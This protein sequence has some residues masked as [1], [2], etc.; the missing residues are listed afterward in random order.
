M[1]RQEYVSR[2][3]RLARNA[4]VLPLLYTAISAF[5]F[6]LAF[7]PWHLWPLAWMALVPFLLAL[8]RVPLGRALLLAWVWTMVLSLTV[9]RWFGSGVASYFGQSRAFGVAVFIAVPT[10]TGALEYMAFAG[11]YRAGRGMGGSVR[12]LLAG[13][14]W[15]AAELC[16]TRLFTGNPWGLLAYSQLDSGPLVHIADTTGVYGV[17]F[18][19]ATFNA[20][21]AGL[22]AARASPRVAWWSA[23]RGVLLSA[24]LG[25]LAL[26]YGWLRVSMTRTEEA[27]VMSRPVAVIQGNVD[28]GTQWRSDF[29]GKNLDVYLGLTAGALRAVSPAV[30]FWP[31]NAMT[32]FLEAEPSY[33]AT[34]ATVLAPGAV[35]LVAGGPRA[36][37]DRHEPYYNSALL[38][39]PDGT[40]AAHYDKERLIPFAERLPLLRS[41]V[42]RRRFGR[43]REFTPGE[44]TPPLQTAAGP[45]GV[46]ICNEG[47]LPELAAARVRAGAG[48]LVI[49]ANDAWAN[50]PQYGMTAIDV[51][52]A[53]AIE[54]RRYVVRSSTSGPSAIIDPWGNVTAESK[55]F[56]RAALTGRLA[57]RRALTPYARLG[58][59]F[60]L[61]CL[62]VT[63]VPVGWWRRADAVASVPGVRARVACRPSVDALETDRG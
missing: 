39:R 48:Y 31:E 47:L 53:R 35:E 10:L 6:G 12:P 4:T 44:P 32:F 57:S 11:C 20:S 7:P 45:A 51:A 62:G 9:I 36:A 40:V 14:A 30:V 58:D 63:A 21:L 43:V 23:L 8:D 52:R 28:I 54:Q 42:L 26:G 18:V 16:R 37:R 2:F 33:R 1:R 38:V 24:T 56:S 60:A 17:S 46:L 5:L 25:T 29:Y 50:D 22:V 34:I 41:E 61:C 49:L 27:G 19:V 59:W 13:A 15:V 55:P 3:G